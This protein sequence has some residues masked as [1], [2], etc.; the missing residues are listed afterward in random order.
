VTDTRPDGLAAEDVIHPF[1]LLIASG[2]A[3]A[4]LLA[5]P[6]A[7]YRAYTWVLTV[8]VIAAGVVALLPRPASTRPAR[9]AAFAILAGLVFP[10]PPSAMVTFVFVATSVAG[11]KV[12]TRRA[13]FLVAA[14]ATV[15]AVAA[16]I[17][18]H[19]IGL[20]VSA[21]AWWLGL[22]VGL[23]VYIGMSR[24]DRATGLRAAREA[25]REAARAAASEAREAALEERGRIAR[26][27]HDVLGHSLTAVAVQLDMADAL[28]QSGRDGDANEAVRAARKLAV[29]A[30]A[31]TRRAV[32]ALRE[33]TLPLAESL[34][35]LADGNHAGYEITGVP[36]P[37][38]VEAA[39]AI[40]R[41]AQ[42]A[43]T[44]AHRYAP[45]GTVTLRLDYEEAVIRLT[46]TDTGARTPTTATGT[47]GG[48][49][50]VGM[51]ERAALQG[52]TLYAGV[53]PSAPGWTV[54]LELPR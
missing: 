39:Q 53:T 37:V 46:V 54:V 41:C 9:C 17:V 7:T 15:T 24:R 50:L 30:I 22:V 4:G 11:E 26:E 13:A 8:L 12:P 52:G 25:A 28:H 21:T 14:A 33:D 18:V 6:P 19:A 1:V 32:Y 10:M 42:E 3:I 31:E 5:H 23:P 34:A 36:G 16:T 45:G 20:P 43:I 40:L 47:G 49:G 48:M 27:I 38:R 29:A 51:R 44:N 35:A 2:A